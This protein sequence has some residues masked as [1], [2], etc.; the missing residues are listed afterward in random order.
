MLKGAAFVLISGLAMCAGNDNPQVQ[1]YKDRVEMGN[2]PFGMFESSSDIGPA[3][4]AATTSYDA[5]TQTYALAGSG[6]G[7]S[8]TA[9]RFQ[10]VWRR[11]AGNYIVS[12][13][14]AFEGDGIDAHSELGWM[15]RT[16][17]DADSAYLS[18]GRR[19][20]GQTVVQFRRNKGAAAERVATEISAADVLQIERQDGRFIVS[21]ARKGD[22]FSSVN[23]AGVTLPDDVFI[24][25][26]VAARN[27]H[28]VEKGVFSN[29]RVTVPA[30]AG[31]QPYRDYYG[32][33]LEIMNVANGH[34]RVVHTESDSLLPPNWTRDGK[35]HIYNRNGRLYRFD[36][37]TRL[38]TEIDTG[39]AIDNNNDHA[40]SFDGRRLAI[41]H[42]SADHERASMIYTMPIAGGKPKLVSRRGPSYFHGWSPD[43]RWL[44]YT[45]GRN[46]SWDIYKMRA[47]G[48][49]D[50][51]RLTDHPALDDGSEFS[52]DGEH[53]Y[54]NSSRSGRMQIWRMRA[55]GSEQEQVSNDG[56]NS[57]F[58]HL[59][60]DGTQMVYLAYMPEVA[61]DDHP[62]YKPVYLMLK[63]VAGGDAK[64]IA[65][66]YGG[67]G[68]INV[69]S[70]SPDGSRI[71]F[72]SN[73]VL[74]DA[75]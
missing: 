50:E 21:V 47:D 48:S 42:H 44:V 34:R 62:W 65:N 72:V 33:R 6:A 10:F 68:T 39:F 37:A 36:L 14:L 40:I 54:F 71:A 66:L 35:A 64:V 74:D 7:G 29:V 18:I 30:P 23:I 3:H 5:E 11:I 15:V 41:S 69:P 13:D 53:I 58:P 27:A 19:G 46:G 17:L 9:D 32:S 57:W 25:L 26:F 4:A 59:S 67:Q 63:P 8:H 49:E 20:N 61:A 38:P 12:A 75:Q 73:S 60:P 43:D 28:V 16:D 22:A 52:P 24:G 1:Y 51:V 55:D 56:Y 45:G 2:K 31:F 70:W